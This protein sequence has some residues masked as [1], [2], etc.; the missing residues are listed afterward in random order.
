MNITNNAGQYVAQLQA[1][2]STQD[3]ATRFEWRMNVADTPDQ[4]LLMAAATNPSNPTSIGNL[5]NTIP[6]G[7]P[8]NTL[9]VGSISTG[10][11][12]FVGK[13]A[14]MI[15]FNRVPSTA[16][17]ATLREYSLKRYGV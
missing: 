17:A 5:I 7:S 15:W 14:D 12:W 8:P 9:R 13:L 1:G 11:Q 2:Q 16:E 6:T 4:S 3:Q 10:G